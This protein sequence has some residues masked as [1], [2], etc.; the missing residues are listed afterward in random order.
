M[1]DIAQ[2]SFEYLKPFFVKPMKDRNTCC[3]IYHVELEELKVALN[4]MRKS[5]NVCSHSPATCIAGSK[6]YAGLTELWESIVCSKGEL[7]EWH[8]RECLMGEC[9]KCGVEKL[10]KFCE[11]ELQGSGSALVDWRRFSLEETISKKGKSLKR[12]TLVYK[13]TTSDEFIDYLK[14]KLDFFV[15]H[16]FVARW[17]D[18][19]FRE[20]LKSFPQDSVVSIVDFAENYTFEVQNEVQSMHWHSFQISILIHICFRHNPNATRYDEDSW[21]LTEYH[22]YISDDPTHDTN[23]VQHCFKLH[24]QYMVERGYAPKRHFVWSD[25]CAQQFKSSKPWYFV[26]KYP[27]ITNGCK[28]LWS[29]FGSAHGKG[30]HDGAGAVVKRYIRNEQRN[31]AG[32]RLTNAAEVVDFLRK[33][34]A[35]RPESSYHGIRKPMK[36]VFWHIETK[37]VDRKC[38]GVQC[39]R[40]HGTMSIHSIYACNKNNLTHLLLRNLACFCKSCLLENW[41]ECPNRSWTGPWRSEHLQPANNNLVRRTMAENWQLHELQFGTDGDELSALLEVGDN[42]AVVASTDND[43]GVEFFLICCSRGFHEVKVAFTCHWG[44]SFQVGDKVVCGTYYQKW[45]R[46]DSSSYVLLNSSKI[47]YLHACHVV[48]IKFLMT[49]TDYRVAGNAPVYNLPTG[50]KDKILSVIAGLEVN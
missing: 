48:V 40:V 46:S 22:F 12:L 7:D 50:A 23:M 9:D 5:K 38:S 1:V 32:A 15:K 45:G 26:S 27:A 2:R 41:D 49:P 28:M 17:E 43:E 10:F 25:G 37:D 47:V 36:R 18:K 29:F 19:Q 30:P 21:I 6:L 14:P 8:K 20:C 11:N 3:C 35:E 16:N 24:W 44:T 13:K 31:V 33:H 39:D 34:L 4:N 42:F